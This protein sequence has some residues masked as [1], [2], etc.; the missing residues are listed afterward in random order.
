MLFS[1][2]ACN[3]QKKESLSDSLP[4]AQGNSSKQKKLGTAKQVWKFWYR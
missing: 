1:I 4:A 2:T 3:E